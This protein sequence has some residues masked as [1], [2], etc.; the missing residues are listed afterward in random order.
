MT[1][2]ENIPLDELYA[3]YRAE[4]QLAQKHREERDRL[5][6]E[7]TRRHNERDARLTDHLGSRDAMGKIPAP[8]RFELLAKL[9]GK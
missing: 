7:L 3:A 9:E 4:V 6:A 8:K 1:D 2:L 5:G